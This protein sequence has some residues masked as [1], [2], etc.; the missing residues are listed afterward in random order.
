M[1]KDTFKYWVSL[2]EIH[3]RQKSRETWLREGDKNTVFFHRIANSHFRKNTLARI[4][5]NGVWLSEEQEIREGI[6]NAFQSLLSDNQEWR[7]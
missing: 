2:E 7:A 4:K 1:V 3:W 6:V 5:I